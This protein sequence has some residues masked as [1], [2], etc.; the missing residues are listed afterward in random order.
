MVKEELDSLMAQGNAMGGGES[1]HSRAA[2]LFS[3]QEAALMAHGLW[4][5]G[6]K[7]GGILE[8]PV[9]VEATFCAE[10]GF[11]SHGFVGW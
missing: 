10:N 6:L 11:S 7:Q 8:E 4:R 2:A 5:I 1:S 3:P 9:H